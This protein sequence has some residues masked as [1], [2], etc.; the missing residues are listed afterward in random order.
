MKRGLLLLLAA[1]AFGAFR[2]DKVAVAEITLQPG[3]TASSALPSVTVACGSG[4]L[5]VTR[6]GGQPEKISVHRGEAACAGPGEMKNTGPS[7]LHYIRVE[8]VGSGL[9]ET[10][11]KSGLAPHYE[12]MLENQYS[13]VYDI[14]IPTHTNEPRHAH[15]AEPGR[16]RSLGDRGGAQGV[17][18]T[19]PTVVASL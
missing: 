2:H 15:R 6:G 10:W 8:F 14:R 4:T 16:H 17:A 12:L 7:A 13:R 5:E 11:G 9:S 19:S 18:V 3:E 1:C